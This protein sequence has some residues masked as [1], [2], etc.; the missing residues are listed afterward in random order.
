MDKTRIENNG[1]KTKNKE[2]KTPCNRELVIV[3]ENSLQETTETEY[4]RHATTQACNNRV[5]PKKNIGKTN[6]ESIENYAL[7]LEATLEEKGIYDVTFKCRNDFL[8]QGP[9]QARCFPNGSWSR[10]LPRCLEQCPNL[11]N[12]I[13]NIQVST[14][15]RT[16]NS[17]VEL[18]CRLPKYE[19]KGLKIL[20]CKH[21]RK[22]T[23]THK[24]EKADYPSCKEK[25]TYTSWKV[26]LI[27][28]GCVAGAILVLVIFLAICIWTR[29]KH[30]KD[31][32]GEVKANPDLLKSLFAAFHVFS[33]DR[34]KSVMILC[35]S[36]EDLCEQALHMLGYKPQYICL[37]NDGTYLESD[38]EL[39][40]FTGSRLMALQ[41]LLRLNPPVEVTTNDGMLI[42]DDATLS[43]HVH[44]VLTVTEV[45]KSQLVI[46]PENG[47]QES[48]ETENDPVD[49]TKEAI[50][51]L[52]LSVCLV[53]AAQN[54][55]SMQ[56]LHHQKKDIGNT[57]IESIENYALDLE[58][59][60][61]GADIY[62]VTFK[63]RN[64]FLLQGPNHVSTRN[65]TINSTVEL[66]CIPPQ[67]EFKE[68]RKLYCK[69]GG[70]WT[71]TH[72]LRRA[73][74]PSCRCKYLYMD[75]ACN[76]QTIKKTSANT[77]IESIENFALD[78]EAT[79]VRKQT[80]DVTF[81]CRN[82]FLLEGPNQARCFQ[83]GSWSREIPKCLEQ[84]ANLV[85]I[86]NIKAKLTQYV[87]GN[88]TVI[89]CES[90]PTKDRGK[91]CRIDYDEGFDLDD[92]ELLR[93]PPHTSPLLMP[94]PEA[95]TT[96]LMIL[97][98]PDTPYHTPR[99]KVKA[100]RSTESEPDNK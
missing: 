61:I 4:D 94:S 23:E 35:F 42:S 67:Y 95:V 100:K 48:T 18:S 34:Q 5:D 8:L 98:R 26:Y 41:L 82:D 7:D 1:L 37:E 72:R 91:R 93:T 9:D 13:E 75:L 6:I 69:H 10:E 31:I 89:E 19:F 36:L 68:P 46:V 66:S 43:Q 86:E 25:P 78:L 80:Y 40:A 54:E 64:D 21:G 87:L 97:E 2:T 51:V 50:I 96:A 88:K 58:A 65:R 32:D 53:I 17:T 71:D 84:C 74:Y 20:N 45:R 11:V 29:R 27:G 79:V 33:H 28:T 73:D 39:M 49:N 30:G 16:I 12:I 77:N 56:R 76:Q 47:L 60:L 62:D 59:I 55:C 81:K 57:N 22:W 44:E 52:I 38:R 14:N 15:K 90:Q 99:N 85:N 3:L 70:W 63:C 92:P 83:N 24:L